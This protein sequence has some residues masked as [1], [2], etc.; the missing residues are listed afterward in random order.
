MM[1]CKDSLNRKY[2]DR[3]LEEYD[4]SSHDV[5]S[6]KL[7]ILKPTIPAEALSP[8][9]SDNNEDRVDDGDDL[10]ASNEVNSEISLFFPFTLSYL[11]LS[12]LELKNKSDRFPLPLF[13]RQEYDIS[14]PI[15]KRPRNSKSSVI[16]SGQPGMGE[17]AGSNQPCRYQGKT[18]YD[19]KVEI[20]GVSLL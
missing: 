19:P 18:A 3:D 10:E 20:C 16:V 1:H 9:H 14:E 13:L 8:R 12:T 4:G 2:S 15:R 6:D 11:D 7:D 17:V 5:L